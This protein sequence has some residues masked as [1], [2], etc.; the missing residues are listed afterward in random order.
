M[1]LASN[2]NLS[3]P[4]QQPVLTAN[5]RLLT[6]SV[7]QSVSSLGKE[8]ACLADSYREAFLLSAL[9]FYL[10]LHVLC[11]C[12]VIIF[13]LNLGWIWGS[14]SR[15]TIGNLRVRDTRSPNT[16]ARSSTLV[17]VENIFKTKERRVEIWLTRKFNNLLV[18]CRKSWHFIGS[19]KCDKVTP[20][21]HEH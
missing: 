17:D 3:Q 9:F 15:H 12:T 7:F 18:S 14:S 13:S 6:V 5:S 19:I 10:L 20:S 1:P 16:V 11:S 4:A 21:L 2:S 8:P